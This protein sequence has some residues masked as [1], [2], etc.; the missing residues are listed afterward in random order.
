VG[1][2]AA[3]RQIGVGRTRHDEQVNDWLDQLSTCQFVLIV[4]PGGVLCVLLG[5]GIPTW[6]SDSR[7]NL[8]LFVG[9]VVVTSLVGLPAMIWQRD[10]RRR[11][12]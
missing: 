5:Y 3:D 2:A 6:L 11:V 1:D 7:F 4:W 9:L 10:R 8:V 12:Q